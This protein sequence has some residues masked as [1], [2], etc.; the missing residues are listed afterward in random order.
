VI[1]VTQAP[2]FATVQDLGRRGHRAIGVPVSGAADRDALVAVNVC[3]GNDVGAAAIELALGRG[4]LRFDADA[5]IAVGGATLVATLANRPVAAW[6][7]IAVR[8]GDELR[9]E[10]VAGGR[11]AYLAVR[12]GI[13]VPV[14]LGSRSTLASAALGGYDGRT[15]RAG[16][17]LSI[18]D[19]AAIGPGPVAS[20]AHDPALP[21]PI[22]RGPQAREFG[23]EAWRTLLDETFRVSRMSDRAGYRLDGAT[24]AHAVA[25]DRPSEPTCVGAIQVPAGGQPI[26]LM[27]DGPTVGG[28]PK[29]AVVRERAIGA[30]AQ[31]A[32]G[33]AVRFVLEE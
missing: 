31:R 5:I 11:F 10:R 21:I 20:I 14:A 6:V 32:P 12:G 30:F 16:D 17:T 15:L 7:P 9:I 13:D 26:V 27:H 3:V 33:D 1:T 24:I 22:V 8:A 28:Y 23:D 2:L 19:A 29:I 18:G 25:T 4:T